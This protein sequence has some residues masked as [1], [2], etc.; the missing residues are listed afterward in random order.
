M[1]SPPF[2]QCLIVG[3]FVANLPV[4]LRNIIINP[5]FTCP[6]EYIG[7]KIIIVLQTIGVASQWI[8]LL[9]TINTERTDTKLHPR[10]D[11]TNRFVKLL[12]QH[13][14]ITT[15]PICLIGETST[16]TGE[17]CI[18]RKIQSIN[19]IRIEIIIHVNSIYIITRHNIGHN[20]TDMLPAFGKCRIEI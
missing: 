16:I 10:L 12:Y 14:H 19:R 18:I 2:H 13:I 8:A 15:T 4:N 9:I 6:K 1:S 20:F 3:S 17:T 5:S 7:I 11:A